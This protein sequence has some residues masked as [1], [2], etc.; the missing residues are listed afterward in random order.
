[1]DGLLIFSVGDSIPLKLVLKKYL[2]H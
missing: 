1:M 2:S